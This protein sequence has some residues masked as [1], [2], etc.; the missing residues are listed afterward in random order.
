MGR[1]MARRRPLTPGLARIAVDLGLRDALDLVEDPTAYTFCHGYFRPRICLTT[2]LA[3]ALDDGELA[4]VM[5]HEAHHVRSRDPLKI[6]LARSMA[7][8]LFYLPVAAVLRDGYFIGKEACADADAEG[9]GGAVELAS[10]LVK[11]LRA[12]RPRWPA[13]ILAIGALSPTESRLERLLAPEDWRVP[14]PTPGVWIA[15]LALVAGLVGFSY[16]AAAAAS[17]DTVAGAC[18]TDLVPT[19]E[20]KPVAASVP[21]EECAGLLDRALPPCTLP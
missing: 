10:A 11:L 15:S 5:R 12:D 20:T 2:G 4:A 6:L 14:R 13:G 21:P 16:G 17:S 18:A 19:S 9:E 7:S 1:I 8:G 3:E